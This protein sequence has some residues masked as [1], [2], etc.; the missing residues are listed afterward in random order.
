MNNELFNYSM[1]F[2]FTIW[3][4]ITLCFKTKSNKRRKLS[5][6]NTTT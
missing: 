5:K 2:C 1:S 4:S 3:I 6:D